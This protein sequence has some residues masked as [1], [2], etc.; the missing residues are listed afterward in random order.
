VQPSSSWSCPACGEKVEDDFDL[1]WNCGTGRE[2]AP[3]SREHLEAAAELGEPLPPRLSPWGA[4]LGGLRV[5]RRRPLILVLGLPDLLYVCVSW[6][7]GVDTLHGLDLHAPITAAAAA[8]MAQT[9]LPS[10]LKSDLFDLPSTLLIG[11]LVFGLTVGFAREQLQ[12]HTPGESALQFAV[13]G[14]P[15]V[16]AYNLVVMAISVLEFLSKSVTRENHSIVVVAAVT[17]A[18]TAWTIATPMFRF[19]E[20][21]ALVTRASP[22][23]AYRTSWRLAK[24]SYW[25]VFWLAFLTVL[26]FMALP[27]FVPFFAAL[28]LWSALQPLID[29]IFTVAY[30]QL[31]DRQ[32]QQLQMRGATE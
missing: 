26:P 22:I 6:L 29:A 20:F 11:P 24:G 28:I 10:V 3:P 13:R 15:R 9:G 23:T 32:R 8:R 30:L 19:A 7:A 5:V 12:R 1:C 25:R 16:A 17:L 14:W 27:F 2:G 18:S 31:V 21:A 4:I